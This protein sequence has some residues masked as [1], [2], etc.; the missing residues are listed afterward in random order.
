MQKEFQSVDFDKSIYG[1]VYLSTL[2]LYATTLDETGDFANAE[3]V[4]LLE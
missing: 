2:G 4:R 3:T 1:R